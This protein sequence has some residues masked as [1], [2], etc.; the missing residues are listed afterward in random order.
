MLAQRVMSDDGSRVFFN[1]Y[2]ALVPGDTNGTQDVYQ[3]ELPGT[4]DCTTANPS[5]SEQNGGCV[6]LIS[7]GQSPQVS[8]FIDASADG[9]DVFF[10][11]GSSLLAPGPGP[12][13]HV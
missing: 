7:S 12:G 8:E 4:G 11:T 1:A 9:K 2:D 13:R 10:T 6:S 5:Y 3:W